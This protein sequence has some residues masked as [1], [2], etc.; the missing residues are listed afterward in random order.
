MPSL[1]PPKEAR[2]RLRP[3]RPHRRPRRRAAPPAPAAGRLSRQA[4]RGC[5]RAA[6]CRAGRR[7][8][9]GRW[10]VGGRH[11]SDGRCRRTGACVR[12]AA[13]AARRRPAVGGGRRRAGRLLWGAAGRG[14]GGHAGGRGESGA[15]SRCCLPVGRRCQRRLLGVQPK[16]GGRRRGAGLVRRAGVGD[17]PG[18]AASGQLPCRC[19]PA[20]TA[21]RDPSRRGRPTD[22]PTDRQPTRPAGKLP[23]H[24][25]RR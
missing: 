22:R 2:R 24:P 14:C 20:R 18:A 17:L 12:G 8:F 13:A 3:P 11:H 5:A 23:A 15:V 10:S 4:L 9:R 1:T 19:G 16:A 6:P 7:L 21:A 25:P